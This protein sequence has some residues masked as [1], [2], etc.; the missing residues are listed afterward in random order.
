MH[1]TENSYFLK[2]ICHL[3]VRKSWLY[4]NCIKPIK[5]KLFR[6][7][8]TKQS[9]MIFSTIL[10]TRFLEC[11]GSCR[12]SVWQIV[13]LINIFEEFFSG[14]LDIF[15]RKLFEIVFFPQ[16]ITFPYLQSIISICHST[17]IYFLNAYD[18]FKRFQNINWKLCL[19][20]KHFCL[21]FIE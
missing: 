16:S 6:K 2:R 5:R 20:L 14:S 3:I 19:I 17:F 7:W 9:N 18:I 4:V 13:V 15:S 1:K 11:Q 10:V 21:N 8:T 12:W